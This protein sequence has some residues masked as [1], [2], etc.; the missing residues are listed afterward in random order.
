MIQSHGDQRPNIKPLNLRY[1]KM[2]WRSLVRSDNTS[3]MCF[4][5]DLLKCNFVVI[6]DELRFYCDSWRVMIFLWFL[7]VVILMSCD[8]WRVVILLCFCCDFA[9]IL[10][11][12]LTSCDFL[13]IFTCWDFWWV[14]ILSLFLTSYE[15]WWVL[16]SCDFAVNLLG[17]LVSCDFWRVGMFFSWLKGYCKISAYKTTERGFLSFHRK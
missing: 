14:G 12:F 15:F 8:F 2:S 5:M 7:R 10:L 17:V 11:W 13:V 9:V 6:F 4:R 1:D 3:K 16:M